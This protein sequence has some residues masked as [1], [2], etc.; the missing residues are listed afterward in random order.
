MPAIKTRVLLIDVWDERRDSRVQILQAQGYEVVVRST[1]V[2][3]M[4]IHNEGSFNLIIVA[5]H[6]DSNLPTEYGD[7]LSKQIPTLPI[8]LLTDQG[9]LVPRGTLSRCVESGSP[10]ELVREIASMLTGSSHLREVDEGV[11]GRGSQE[12]RVW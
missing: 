9:V 4:R 10:K 1:Y 12:S 8:L 3:A 6:T 11:Q 5:V 7:T 2:D